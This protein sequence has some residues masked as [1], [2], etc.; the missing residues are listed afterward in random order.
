MPSLAKAAAR[1]KSRKRDPSRNF[2]RTSVYIL[3]HAVAPDGYSGS[4][5]FGVGYS[6]L[7]GVCFCGANPVNNSASPTRT[8][9]LPLSATIVTDPLG[10]SGNDG[11][12]HQQPG[13]E[14][15]PLIEE[16]MGLTAATNRTLSERLR[17]IAN[18]QPH[19]PAS[20]IPFGLRH[21]HLDSSQHIRPQP[22]YTDSV[23][24]GQDGIDIEGLQLRFHQVG[25]VSRAVCAH[26]HQLLRHNRSIPPAALHWSR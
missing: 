24:V 3:L 14:T 22:V 1:A 8:L 11:H 17:G 26:R 13:Q 9:R 20:L 10:K 18:R 2:M 6:T 19:D 23:I 16:V 7:D 21:P 25:L 15:T 4:R 5:M 12:A